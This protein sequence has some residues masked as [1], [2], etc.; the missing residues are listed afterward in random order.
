MQRLSLWR[1]PS[2]FSCCWQL[3]KNLFKLKFPLGLGVS[4]LQQKQLIIQQQKKRKTQSDRGES[5]HKLFF[6]HLPEQKCV[7]LSFAC[8]CWFYLFSVHVSVKSYFL[9]SLKPFCR[10]QRYEKSTNYYFTVADNGNNLHL[11]LFSIFSQRHH[12]H[13]LFA[14]PLFLPFHALI[15]ILPLMRLCFVCL[16]FSC[17]E[18]RS[19]KKKHINS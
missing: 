7:F 12:F 19:K 15:S 9:D 4:I 18:W 17:A 3:G 11:E 2:F 10:R 13:L 14:F 16:L 1:I 6:I 8:F 5:E